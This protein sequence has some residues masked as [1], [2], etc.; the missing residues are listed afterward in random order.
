[1]SAYR[2]L[3]ISAVTDVMAEAGLLETT[4]GEIAATDE[5]HAVISTIG[6][7][8]DLQGYLMLCFDQ[9][10]YVGFVDSLSSALGMERSSD[11]TYRRA[12][13]GEVANQLAG[14]ASMLL[15]EIGADCNITP[16]TVVT[17]ANVTAGLQ[18]PDE[19]IFFSAKGSFGHANLF[20]GLKKR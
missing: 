17:G 2:D 19:E 5:A 7:T 9:S 18:S 1:M 14:R 13:I 3:F 12:V 4:I 16:P 11:D 6:I 10:S 8:G 15:A 20:V